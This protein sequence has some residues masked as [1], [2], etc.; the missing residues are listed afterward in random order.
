MQ[1]SL[2]YIRIVGPGVDALDQRRE[3]GS[4]V[5]TTLDDERKSIRKV[6]PAITAGF[7]ALVSKCT[8]T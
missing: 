3:T 6:M 5:A 7:R 8:W 4:A 2:R 1:G